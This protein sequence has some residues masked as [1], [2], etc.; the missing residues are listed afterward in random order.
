MS[1]ES[2]R[3]Q[4]AGCHWT[5]NFAKV[6]NA[7]ADHSRGNGGVHTELAVP[8]VRALEPAPLRVVNS[9]QWL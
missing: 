6:Q 4:Y 9:K 7:A 5:G 2:K 1:H 3:H 8:A